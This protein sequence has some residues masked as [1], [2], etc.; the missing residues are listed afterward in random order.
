MTAPA[1]TDSPPRRRTEDRNPQP[2]LMARH[3][4]TV[5]TLQ[6]LAHQCIAGVV[7][8]LLLVPPTPLPWLLQQIA[9]QAAACACPPE[10]CQ[11]RD[12]GGTDAGHAVP[13]H[14]ADTPDFTAQAASHAAPAVLQPEKSASKPASRCGARSTETGTAFCGCSNH[15]PA[16]PATLLII[17]QCIG[18]VTGVLATT[19][20]QQLRYA[21]WRSS[22]P[23]SIGS[24][25]FHPPRFR[26]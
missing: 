16:S 19:L 2:D 26:A 11:C 22:P 10:L 9:P 14:R 24:D 4:N 3:R 13:H 17:D 15:Q 5:K 1:E 23:S 20:P 7:A 21:P 6:T 25:I 18:E 8:L 12:H